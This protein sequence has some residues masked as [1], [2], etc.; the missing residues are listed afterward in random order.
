[1][2]LINLQDYPNNKDISHIEYV[3]CNSAIVDDERNAQN[4]SI[5]FS[6]TILRRK[7]FDSASL[8]VNPHLVIT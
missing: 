2:K 5:M 6:S 4:S 7:C 3:V 1:V 8:C